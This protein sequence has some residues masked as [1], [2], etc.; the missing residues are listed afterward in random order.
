MGQRDENAPELRS[1]GHMPDFAARINPKS[2]Y[3][4]LS[5]AI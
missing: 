3:P 1:G 2:F 4:K 5:A